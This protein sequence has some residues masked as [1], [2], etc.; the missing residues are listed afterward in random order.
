MP[1][2]EEDTGRV[3]RVAQ[4]VVDR[5]LH[6][7]PRDCNEVHRIER[8]ER[9]L[10]SAVTRIKAVEV[11]MSDGR[12]TF[13]EIQ[14]GQLSMQK[15]LDS[16]SGTLSKLNWIVLTAVIVAVISLVVKATH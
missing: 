5:S 14:A 10:E 6:A 13:A 16:I 12:V 3:E 11:G 7:L 15:S 8:L 2:G 1:H 9:D 4:R